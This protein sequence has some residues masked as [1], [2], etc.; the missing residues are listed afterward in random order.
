[1]GKK[2]RKRAGGFGLAAYVCGII[3]LFIFPFI[4]STLAIIFGAIGMSRHQKFA[5]AGLVLGM[6]GWALMLFMFMITIAAFW[7][8]IA[9]LF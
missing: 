5:V 3:G 2:D 4:L 9:V 8:N 1:M 7:G 6:V